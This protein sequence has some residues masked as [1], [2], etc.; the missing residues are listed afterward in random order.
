LFSIICPNTTNASFEIGFAFASVT[1]H[2][3]DSGENATHIEHDANVP[4][5]ITP[6]G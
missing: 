3:G 6:I 5:I 1:V 4:V 2:A